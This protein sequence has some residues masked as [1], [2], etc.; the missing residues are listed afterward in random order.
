[1]EISLGYIACA[2]LLFML[3]WLISRTGRG[4]NYSGNVRPRTGPSHRDTTPDRPSKK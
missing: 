1:M 4:S 2:Y 3:C